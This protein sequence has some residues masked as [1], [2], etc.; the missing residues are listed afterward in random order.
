MTA[1]GANT[2]FSTINAIANSADNTFVV[3]NTKVGTYY[4]LVTQAATSP[5]NLIC[6]YTTA[7]GGIRVPGGVGS[8]NTLTLPTGAGATTVLQLTVFANNGPAYVTASY[9]FN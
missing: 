5:K 4:V 8:D 9:D 7:N 6:Q 1:S 3:S 2:Q